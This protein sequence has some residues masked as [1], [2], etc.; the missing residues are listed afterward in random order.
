MNSSD[1]CLPKSNCADQRSQCLIS[2]LLSWLLLILQC[3]L[4]CARTV[5]W[6]VWIAAQTLRA[7]LAGRAPW[8]LDPPKSPR[9]IGVSLQL[10]PSSLE[11]AV[12]RL[13]LV[14]LVLCQ[15]LSRA[16]RASGR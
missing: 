13:R 16:A 8:Q 11:T 5:Q 3:A 9:H 15:C 4:A 1:R 6:G 7:R 14:R 2:L 10:R 12:A